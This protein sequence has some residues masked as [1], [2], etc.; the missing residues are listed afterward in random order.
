M[1]LIMACTCV[2]VRHF[3]GRLN[4][5]DG[6]G[7]RGGGGGRS[8]QA[9]SSRGRAASYLCQRML[10]C[11]ILMTHH[12]DDAPYTNDA[13]L[14]GIQKIHNSFKTKRQRQLG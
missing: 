10:T 14:K 4:G 3:F 9:I 7:G 1:A 6:A 5:T 12:I 2:S 13:P 11:A 8:T